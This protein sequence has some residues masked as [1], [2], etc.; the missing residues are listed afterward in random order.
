MTDQLADGCYHLTRSQLLYDLYVAF[1][2][3]A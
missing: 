2:D 1:Y 3:A